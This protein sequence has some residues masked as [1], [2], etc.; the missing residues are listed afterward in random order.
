MNLQ[1]CKINKGQ[2]LQ[3]LGVI[4]DLYNEKWSMCTQG[5]DKVMTMPGDSGRPG[6]Y[7]HFYNFNVE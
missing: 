5:T 1:A 3:K 6:E 4:A 2:C 7:S